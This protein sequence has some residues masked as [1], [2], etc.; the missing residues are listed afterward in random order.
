MTYDQYLVA[1]A[2]TN[3]PATPPGVVVAEVELDLPLW[4]GAALS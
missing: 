1:V 3:G 4:S 2:M